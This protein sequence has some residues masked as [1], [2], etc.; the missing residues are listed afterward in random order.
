MVAPIPKSSTHHLR[1]SNH[2]LLLRPQKLSCDPAEHRHQQGT[3]SLLPQ[4][5]STRSDRQEMRPPSWFPPQTRNPSTGAFGS[6]RGANSRPRSETPSRKPESG[7][8]LSTQPSTP[9]TPTT[10]PPSPSV[11]PRPRPTF[12][13]CPSPSP[14]L[15]TRTTTTL[16]V[17]INFKP[18]PPRV[19]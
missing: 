4:A 3:P 2:L 1:S 12:P 17:I 15:P 16:P 6:G 10:Q 18:Y 19:V 14:I 8:A 5:W 7:S 9:P 13:F 11:D